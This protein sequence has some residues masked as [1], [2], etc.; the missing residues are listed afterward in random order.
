MRDFAYHIFV[1]IWAVF[2]KVR[3]KNLIF[4]LNKI[5]D[6]FKIFR[7]FQKICTFVYNVHMIV[8]GVML[9][10]GIIYSIFLMGFSQSI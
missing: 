6:L 3:L 5:H 1:C 2:W 4:N 8:G 7:G 10:F 9:K